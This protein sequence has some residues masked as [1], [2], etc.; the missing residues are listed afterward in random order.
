[1][2][3][4]QKYTLEEGLVLIQEELKG[5]RDAPLEDPTELPLKQIRMAQSVFQPRDFSEAGVSYSEDH[6][7]VLLEALSSNPQGK[8][9][10]LLVWW[11]GKSWR[12]IDG[13][14]RL[15]AYDRWN[16][17]RPNTLGDIPV[18]V[19]KG[20]LEEAMLE[21]ARQNSKDKLP[22]SK[23]EK[24]NRAWKFTHS[25]IG[26]KKTIS[27]ACKVSAQTV[28]NMRRKL[29]EIKAW[30]PQHWEAWCTSSTWEKAKKFGQEER[31]VNDG[32][33][34]KLAKQWTDR[35]GVAFGTKFARQPEIAAMALELYSEKLVES[36]CDEWHDIFKERI[37]QLEDDPLDHLPK[38]T[39]ESDNSDF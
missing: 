21:A 30:S 4:N 13:H 17:Q 33:K 31:E 5:G 18:K 20:S 24:L 1:M 7:R 25:G 19:F 9:D 26:S 23:T 39:G 12:V 10:P 14:H 32:W 22:M 35:L 3:F 8:L 38:I 34:E 29:E 2:S 16:K 28:A 11:S 27:E 36:L 6:I 37:E 15:L